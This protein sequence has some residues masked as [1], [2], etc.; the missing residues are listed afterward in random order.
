MADM[1]KR[2]YKRINIT[3]TSEYIVSIGG[4]LAGDV[5]FV[6]AVISKDLPAGSYQSIPITLPSAAEGRGIVYPTQYDGSALIIQ[7]SGSFSFGTAQDRNKIGSCRI[8]NGSISICI[9]EA[10]NANFFVSF[11]VAYPKV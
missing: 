10:A 4:L 6:D 9:N 1:I 8:S 5:L 3:S 2:G 7:P 11:V